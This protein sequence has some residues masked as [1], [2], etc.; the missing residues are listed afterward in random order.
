MKIYNTLNRKIEELTPIN[1]QSF[2]VYSCGP[3][4]YDEAHI[5]N[6]RAFIYAD[7]ISR[8]LRAEGSTVK[9]VMNITDVDDKT[10]SR[11]LKD[12]PNLEPMVALHELT[13]KYEAIFLK[14]LELLNI[15]K[16][17]FKFIRAT[18]SIDDIQKIIIDLFNKKIA[19]IAND[20]IY[21][22][23]QEYKKQGHKYGQ[24]LSIDEE[25]SNSLHRIDNDEYDKNTI[26]DFALWKKQKDNEPSWD[27]SIGDITMNG[28]PGWHIECSA[29]SSSSLGQPFDIHTGGIDLIF[30][31]HENEIAQSEATNNESLAKYWIHSDHISIDGD[32]I[33]KSLG[34]GITL[35]DIINKGYS[36]ET[37]R[38]FILQSLYQNQSSFTYD[39]LDKSHNSLSNIVRDF[40]WIYSIDKLEETNNK[41]NLALSEYKNKI[42]STVSENLNTPMTIALLH[43]ISTKVSL[44]THISSDNIKKIELFAIFIKEL[45][46]I[47]ILIKLE[48]TDDQANMIV[49]RTLARKNME[50]D[51]AD[52]L[53]QDL[54][55]QKIGIKDVNDTSI[56]YP[57]V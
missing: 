4:V 35:T 34:N 42:K 44:S 41:L 18:E 16:D 14:D 19:Y 36:P 53:R 1:P 13:H 55:L 30:P 51:I 28:R 15:K 25:S 40:S 39:L 17:N 6:L 23:I 50:W 32:K 31:H 49:R 21:F 54:E 9:H 57:I 38:L 52:K 22:S 47:N 37:F 48:L 10:I 11:S 2:R 56:W 12:Y 7:L 27:F 20:G 29:M 26:Q 8:V 43:E 46:G 33:S 5:G 24:L 3:T 45:L